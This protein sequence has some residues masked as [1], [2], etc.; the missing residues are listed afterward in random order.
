MKS[1]TSLQNQLIKEIAALH[2][3]KERKLQGK[4]LAE[5]IRTIETI[6]QTLQP[7]HLFVTEKN[8]SQALEFTVEE[9]IYIVTQAIMEKISTASTASGLLGIFSIP[10]PV[11]PL[12]AGL[13]L[14]DITDPGNM[15]TLI[16][17]AVACNITT[18]VTIEGTDPW[19]PKVIQATAGTIASVSIYQY[20]WAELIAHKK[21]LQLYALV[22]TGGASLQTV[23][24]SNSLLVVGNEA[25][26]IK[27]EWLS[28]C[29]HKITLPMASNIESLNAAIAGSIALYITHMSC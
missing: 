27:P 3:A 15:G 6:C 16:R 17:T 19:S 22:V 28:D 29:E 8:V 13:V 23:N 18:I 24:K 26:G 11:S 14:A 9:N 5:G 4:F 7:L 10:Q 12:S 1:I 2:T 20:T 21:E 25:H